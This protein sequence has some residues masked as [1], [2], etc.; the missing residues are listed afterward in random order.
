M[1][2][3]PLRTSY[4]PADTTAP[5]LD[6][7]I[8]GVL[9]V[10][11]GRAPGQSGL[12]AGDPGQARRRPWSYAQLLTEAER[13]AHALLARFQ[14]GDPVA[15]WSGACRSSIRPARHRCCTPWGRPAGPRPRCSLT[16]G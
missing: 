3:P 12:V 6:T 8:G 14:P 10:A 7:T 15:V 16:A 4:W 2:H 13:A 9:R 1:P 5:V 11:A